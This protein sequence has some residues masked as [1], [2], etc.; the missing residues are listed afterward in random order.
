VTSGAEPL[1]LYVHVPFCEAKCAYCHF[2]IDPRRPD[3]DRQERYLRA[4][5]VE[6]GGAE[7]TKA[8]TLYLGGGTPSL[9]APARLGRLVEEARHR[10]RLDPAG[11]VT[12][13][14][15][16]SDLDRAGYEELLALGANRLSL[17]VQSLDDGTLR[18][19]GRRHDAADCVRAVGL[20]RA[21]GFSNVS[22]DLVLGWPGEARERWRRGLDT[23]LSLA[24]EH[25]SL[26]LLEAEPRT[27]LAHR[28]RR[29][30]VALPPDDLVAD[31]YQETVDRLAAA[32]LERYE[33][34]NF[35]RPGFASRHNGK[36]WDDAPFLGFGMS[37]HAYRDGRRS[38]N[39]DRYAT[40][41]R[42]IEQ[43][44]PGAAT[45]GERV[46][47]A[48]ERAAEALFTGLRR[49]EGVSVEAFRHRYGLDPLAEWGDALDESARAGLVRTTEGCLRLTDRGMLLSN[50][51]F[52][53]FV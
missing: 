39:H 17:G 41:C 44:G 48:R 51:V 49:R 43:G 40:Y 35:A 27:A 16:P 5:L 26:Y 23:V 33:I 36:Y 18:D 29:G 13:E 9:M 7:A 2:A 34:S 25:V 32:G 14:A 20:A 6:M 31:L 52:R 15:N 8:D 12:V 10:F 42:A 28:L 1:G 37:A 3:V 47:K 22:V 46:L 4:V 24:P 11:E 30:T 50:E 45:A 21:A 38:W 53:A 19:M